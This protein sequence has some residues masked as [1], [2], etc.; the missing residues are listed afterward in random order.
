MTVDNDGATFDG[1]SFASL[2]LKLVKSNI[3]LLPETRQTEAEIPG[4]DGSLDMGAEYGP[5]LI[6]LE[7]ILQESSEIQ[8]QNK[9][10]QLAK[11]FNARAG[12]K[13]L[14]LDRM[15]GKRWLCK[16]NGSI[17]IEK[18]LQ[19]GSFTLPLK[20]FSPFSE[21]VHHTT[22]PLRYGQGYTYGMGLRRGSQYS[23]AVKSSPQL[24]TVHHAGTHEAYPVIT[25]TGSASNLT[26][27]NTTT[28]ESCSVNVTLGP[29]DVLELN[30]APM[31]QTAKKNGINV[32]GL[33][34]GRFPKLIEGL[35]SLTITATS[36]NMTVAFRFRHT[37][38]Y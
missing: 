13:S 28:G 36:P 32:L 24:I 33:F 25:I 12:A 2:G 34:S 31:E 29:T 10:Q 26:I 35:N 18:L 19:L 20:A 22:Y 30:C 27:T 7:V 23:F 5:R 16:Y 37:Y 4:L 38:L 1:I 9:L 8:Y 11:L 15:P 6:E 17:G 3:P 14:V 21:S